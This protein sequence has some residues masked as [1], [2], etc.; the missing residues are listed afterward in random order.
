MAALIFV[1]RGLSALNSPVTKE[2]ENGRQNFVALNWTIKY[3]K[4][5]KRK[6]EKRERKKRKE[7]K[8]EERG[9]KRG[10]K[11]LEPKSKR[12]GRLGAKQTHLHV[13][14]VLPKK[15]L[16]KFQI[17]QAHFSRADEGR[18]QKNPSSKSSKS[19]AINS[20]TWDNKGSEKKSSEN[21]SNLSLF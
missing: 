2:F 18:V 14:P 11:P 15:K 6:E 21:F 10:G 7:E 1:N 9:G 16:K 4:R 17:I 20:A 12:K 8:R 3:Q 5:G 13:Q 19:C